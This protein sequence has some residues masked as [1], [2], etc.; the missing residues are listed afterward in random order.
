MKNLI[1][2]AIII[3]LAL[4]ACTEPIDLELNK[5]ENVRLVVDALI[6]TESKAHL[7]DLSLT[8][9][10][11]KEGTAD[12]AR[13]AIVTISDGNTTETLSELEPGKYYTSESYA[14]EVNKTYTLTI[15]YNEEIYSS[16][17][18]LPS[19]ATLDSIQVEYFEPIII[20][21]EEEEETGPADN[22]MVF[23]YF[24]EPSTPGDY[25]IFKMLINGEYFTGS[26]EDWFFTDD[27]A[28]NGSYIG[29][30]EF[31]RFYAE[32]GD[33]ITFEQFSMTEEVY[34]NLQAV[35]L[36]TVFRGGLFDG[37]PANVPSNISN[38]AVG[39]FIAADIETKS[40]VIE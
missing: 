9:D 24:Q 18:I 31:F 33:T 12:R 11:F 26:I 17:S 19:V 29:D 7:V 14:G 37:A 13:D 27:V 4:S 28:V 10:Y 6:T 30:A 16:T 40:V 2:T 35:L 38:G 15:D 1:Y 21:G 22:Y 8:S 20:P 32:P 36:E 23:P 3:S 5:E 39:A 34:D 25:Y